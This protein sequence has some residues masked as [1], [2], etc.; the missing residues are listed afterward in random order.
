MAT[1]WWLWAV[2]RRGS[3]DRRRRGKALA[4]AAEGQAEDGFHV[5]FEQT[6]FFGRVGIP[7]DQGLVAAAR[8]GHVV[9]TKGDGEEAALRPGAAQSLFEVRLGEVPE[10]NGAV[11]AATGEP[12]G[13]AIERHAEHVSLVPLE[14]VFDFAGGNVPNFD[15]AVPTVLASSLPSRLKATPCT[16]FVCSRSVRFSL[17][18]ARSQ[19]LTV[20]S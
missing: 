11:L 9:R 2:A 10:A 1:S 8:Q 18:L 7:E 16:K 6:V 3:C 19:I 5:A 4:V 17:P 15:R 12:P 13:V 20:W 14:A